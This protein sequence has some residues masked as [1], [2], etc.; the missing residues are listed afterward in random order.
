MSYLDYFDD[1]EIAAHESA[2]QAVRDKRAAAEQGLR[3]EIERMHK[4]LEERQAREV[5]E[6]VRRRRFSLRVSLWGKS[7]SAAST[8]RLL[9]T[10]WS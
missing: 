8:T 1:E 4:E 3:D 9:M 2:M 6:C 10:S 5:K 7:S